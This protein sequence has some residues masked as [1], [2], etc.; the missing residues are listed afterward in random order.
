MC[1]QTVRGAQLVLKS[2][3]LLN[4][5]SQPALDPS[6]ASTTFMIEGHMLKIRMKRLAD[7][8]DY[9]VRRLAEIDASIAN[10]SDEDLREPDS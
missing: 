7:R 4:D 9:A 5:L 1:L 8:G 10:L 3:R 2:R 6:A